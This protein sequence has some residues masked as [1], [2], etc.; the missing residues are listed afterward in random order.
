M[1]DKKVEI[2]LIIPCFNEEKNIPMFF[3]ETTKIFELKTN[4][5][6][7]L[8]FINDGST[9]N[10]F[11]SLTK[12]CENNKK[13]ISIINFS[14]NFGKEAAM[15]AGLKE[16]NGEFVCIIDADMQQHPKYVLEM[17]EFLLAHEEY[18]CVTAYQEQRNEGKLLSFYKKCFYKLIN[19]I[20]EVKFVNGASDFRMFRKYMVDAI[21]ELP[22]SNRFSKGIFSWVGFQTYYFPYEVRERVNGTS[23][24][25]FWKLLKYAIEGLVSFTIVPLRISTCVGFGISITA[26]LYLIVVIIQKLAFGIQIEGYATII[27][28][29]LLLGGIQLLVLGVIG[30][31]IAKVYL[32]TKKRPPYIVKEKIN[33][34]EV[35]E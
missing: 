11:Q 10:T 23:S 22:E 19:R 2:S 4:I 33:V 8:I 25:S 7:E 28:L 18:D 1:I 32:E 12:I 6:Y 15:L 16:A 21:L 35:K 14:R 29:I 13:P 20:S 9:D 3:Q 34:N 17:Y 27:V 31:Y 30:E 24:W 26:F 5:H